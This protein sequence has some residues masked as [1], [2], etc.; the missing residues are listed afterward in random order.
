MHVSIRILSDLLQLLK[1]ETSPKRKFQTYENIW[2][3][4]SPCIILYSNK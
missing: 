4:L 2:V 1:K 3:L